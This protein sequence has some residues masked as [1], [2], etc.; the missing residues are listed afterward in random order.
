MPAGFFSSYNESKLTYSGTYEAGA[1]PSV[2]GESRRFCSRPKRST[3][4]KALLGEEGRYQSLQRREV[5]V[6]RRHCE[7]VK[8]G[9]QQAMKVLA[10]AWLT[11]M[12]LL[13]VSAEMNGVVVSVADGDTVTLAD[14]SGQRTKIRLAEIDAPERGQ[15]Y[16]RVSRKSLVDLCQGVT[17]RV[18]PQSTDRFGRTVGRLHCGNSDASLH[19]VQSGLAWAFTKYL[20]DQSIQVE[21]Q[22][23]RAAGVGLWQDPSPVPPWEFRLSKSQ[24]NN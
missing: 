12:P 20:T 11:L 8:E 15:P 21:E 14:S 4:A 9:V 18:V 5:R 3:R 22:R 24:A 13:S 17:A 23:A 7:Q 10:A 16:N 6:Q 1:N 2:R 19:Q